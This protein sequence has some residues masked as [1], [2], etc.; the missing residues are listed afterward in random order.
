[1]TPALAAEQVR[2]CRGMYGD[3]PSFR[4]LDR[5]MKVP[6][7]TVRRDLEIDAKPAAERG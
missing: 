6:Q 2:E 7:G 3:T 4:R 5:T 1:M